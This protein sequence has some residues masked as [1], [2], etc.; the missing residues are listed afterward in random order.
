[1]AV[2]GQLSVVGKKVRMVTQF[3]VIFLEYFAGDVLISLFEKM[4][5]CVYGASY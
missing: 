5:V 2:S 4:L 3:T 1:M